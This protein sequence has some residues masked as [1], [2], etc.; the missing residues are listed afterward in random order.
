MH[1]SRLF[2]SCLAR[3]AVLTHIA[4]YSKILE[5][6]ISQTTLAHRL[7][8]KAWKTGGQSKQQALLSRLFK[9]YFETCEN[10]G[11]TQVLAKAAVAA[12]VM[13]LEEVCVRPFP[14]PGRLTNEVT[15][16]CKV[17]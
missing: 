10:I 6:V 15:V 1:I 11:D 8:F 9:A 14:N 13:S 5:G 2:C 3:K 17:S 16:G 4:Q 7:L 12:D